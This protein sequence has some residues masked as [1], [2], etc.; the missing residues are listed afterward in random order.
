MLKKEKEALA[1]RFQV[2]DMGEV[3]YVL[4]M[5]VKRNREART[6]TINQPPKYLEGVLKRFGMQEC[7]PV[8]TPLE[9]GRKFE[10][11]SENDTPIDVREYQMAIG[12]LT[13]ATTATR[14]DLAAAVGIL[15]KYMARPGK[16]HWQ[17]VKEFY[18]MSKGHLILVSR[19]L[20]MVII[21]Y[22][23]VMLM[24]TGEAMS[25][26]DVLIWICVPDTEQHD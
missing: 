24:L 6:L 22:C 7:K 21:L 1:K 9:P 20:L 15:S 14:P 11:L 4:G 8:S 18:D 2:E 10:S 13:Y 25:K 23:M 3:S 19:L 17:G 16:D 12:C 26:L 5:S